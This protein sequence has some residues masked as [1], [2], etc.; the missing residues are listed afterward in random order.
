ML[1]ALPAR[2]RRAVADLTFLAQPPLAAERSAV[3][4]DWRAFAEAAFGDLGERGDAPPALLLPPAVVVAA[5]T[6]DLRP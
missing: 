3:I 1:V 5:Y 6:L 2:R 4:E